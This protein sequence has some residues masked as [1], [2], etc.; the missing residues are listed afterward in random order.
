MGDVISI[1]GRD[2]RQA[3]RA[4]VLGGLTQLADRK[5]VPLTPALS[6]TLAEG[7]LARMDMAALCQLV[8]QHEA[9]LTVMVRE[10]NAEL[11][12]SMLMRLWELIALFERKTDF[13]DPAVR[14]TGAAIM[15]KF[16][17]SA[18][19]QGFTRWPDSMQLVAGHYA[20]VPRGPIVETR[21]DGAR[22]T[23]Y[24]LGRK[25]HRDPKDGPAMHCVWGEIEGWEYWVRGQLHRSHEDGPAMIYTHYKDFDL[26][27]EEYFENGKRHRP[28]HLGPAV[29]HRDRNGEVVMEFYIEHGQLHRDPSDG[30][31]WWNVIDARTDRSAERPC[32]EIKYY[33]RGQLQRDSNEGPALAKRDNETGVLVVE[34]YWRDG[35]FHR[36]DGPAFIERSPEGRCDL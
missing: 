4:F 23:T 25:L 26:S 9:G 19:E 28:S 16:T 8:G 14:A 22:F 6:D 24:W 18:P 33:E 34:E 13:T 3:A 12:A 2:I 20:G 11:D 32:T 21:D 15:E 35:G 30:P 10:A 5:N 29:T 1:S 7:V 31:A 27:G 17:A 36:E